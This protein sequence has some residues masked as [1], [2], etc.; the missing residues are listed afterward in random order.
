MVTTPERFRLAAVSTTTLYRIGG[1]PP[2]R[3]RVES[4]AL[5]CCSLEVESA[6]RSGLLVPDD[7]DVEADLTVI[8]VAGTV[9]DVLA[10]VVAR[11]RDSASTPVAVVAYG[12]C[13]STGGPYWDAPTVS[14]GVDQLIPVDAYVPGCPP[15]PQALVACLREL[16]VRVPA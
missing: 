4:V 3:I 12:V 6:V 9:T 7:D 1:D 14:K 2:V 10:P 15:P 8:L 5:A 13:A 16:A 11:L